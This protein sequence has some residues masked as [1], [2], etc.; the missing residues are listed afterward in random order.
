MRN[1]LFVL[2]RQF[3]NQASQASGAEQQIAI[4]KA[5]NALSSA[6]ANAT[7]AEQAQ[8]YTMQEELESL[9]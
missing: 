1:E 3:V 9:Q 6:F 5:K 2:A 7:L 8:L 4:D